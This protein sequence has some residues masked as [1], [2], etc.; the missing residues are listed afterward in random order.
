M[1]RLLCLL[2]LCAVPLH[3]A[4]SQPLP[5]AGVTDPMTP[6]SGSLM[7]AGKADLSNVTLRTFAWLAGEQEGN[8]V[9]VTNGDQSVDA[10][11]W[12]RAM[13]K[14]TVLEINDASQA[15]SDETIMAIADATGIWF[16]CDVTSVALE[17][18]FTKELGEAFQNGAA[19]G[20]HGS[21]AECLGEQIFNDDQMRPG[22]GLLPHSCVRTM[23]D[24]ESATKIGD[25][26]A[27]LVHWEIPPSGVLVMHDGRK[28]AVIGEAEI[29]ARVPAANGWAE[30]V[31][32]FGARVV[33]LPFT[34]DLVSWTRSAQSRTRPVFPPTNPPA[35]E[36]PS[37]T[38]ILIG[39][40]GSTDDMWD[41]FID[42]AGGTDANFVCIPQ[43]NDSF[44][45]R[46]LRD[47]GCKNVTVLFS[48]EDL[49][50]K[51]ESDEEFLEPLKNA[52]AV[53]LGGGRTYRFMDAYQHTTAHR[54]MM[55]VL[56]RGGVIAGTSAGAQIQGDF[57]VRG[58]P[59]TNQTLW[60]P[61]NDTGFA[62]LRGVIV[63]VHFA[64]R[65]REETLPALLNQHPQ[66]LGIGI[67]E[68]TA[69]VVTGQKAEVLGRG[70]AWFYDSVDR[71]DPKP[72][73]PV[74]LQTGQAYDLKAR[75]TLP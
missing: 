12:Q 73:V 16:A 2:V 19:V 24:D 53:F 25:G 26:Q 8:L 38:L 46:K 74:V 49:R 22:F 29:T 28:V 54:L 27:N 65:G 51:A 47:R 75:K 48:D 62:F 64:E 9:I 60:Y 56:K 37:G 5:T 23:G 15:E 35:V 21:G 70:S 66:M 11:P 7:L 36:V 58:D 42:S 6:L 69:I 41:R 45:S 72:R 68:A 32:T 40:G 52:D 57:L 17:T 50:S 4:V 30:R 18:C 67:D 55:D 39:G 44:S 34:T 14:V 71:D 59:R 1:T 3:H 13:G 31:E 61:G 63:D 33:A 10:G 20:G 43:S